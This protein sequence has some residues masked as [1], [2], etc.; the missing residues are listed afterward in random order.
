MKI[1]N[2]ITVCLMCCG[3]A[4]AFTSCSKNEEAF[5]TAT[6]YDAPRILNRDLPDKFA[7]GVPQVYRTINRD[8]TFTLTIQVTPANYTTVTWLIDGE[9]KGEG[10]EFTSPLLT[11][12]THLLSI[13]ATTTMGLSTSRTFYII[14]NPL[15]ND[16]TSTSTEVS[17]R[18][19]TPGAPAKLSGEHLDGIKKVSVNGQ[20]VDA[21]YNAA[22]GCIEYTVPAGLTDGTY[23][24]NFIDASGQEFGAG[25]VTVVTKPTANTY[26]F[27]GKEAGGVLTIEGSFLNKVNAIYIN[28]QSCEITA[29]SDD[30]LTVQTPAM[31]IG[32]YVLTGTTES[33]EALQFYNNSELLNC[34]VDAAN[35]KVT[36]ETTLLE[37]N[38]EINWDAAICHLTPAQL[39]EVPV[40]STILIYYEVPEAEYHNLRIVT[41][42]WNDVPGG[43]QID[44]TADTPNP[45]ELTYTQE[46]KDLVMEQEGMS[47]VGFGYTVKS[48]TYK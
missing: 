15:E 5:F 28:G 26:S 36:Q 47:C 46:F 41:N 31:A 1:K 45:Y 12:G 33:G 4:V 7:G 23:S 14:V 21:V 37:G 22:D 27:T 9:L 6:E 30:K 24:I 20:Q 35:F 17:E 40:G 18:L 13:V 43:A 44:V 25:R 32:S 2:I 8:E 19:L 39:S 48:I 29:K 42:W 38:Y 3:F 16:P 11:A 10:T 34:L